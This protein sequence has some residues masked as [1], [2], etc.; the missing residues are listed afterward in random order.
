MAE[1]PDA[2]PEWQEDLAAYV[3]AQGTPE[4]EAALLAHLATCPACRAEADEL[5]AIAAVVLVMDPDRS[6]PAPAGAQPIAPTQD[7]V[8]PPAALG[9]R[10]A[11]RLASERRRNL[12]RRSFVAAIAAA[13]AAVAGVTT[14]H[15]LAD[16]GPGHL[17]GQHFAFA[18]RP[19]GSTVEA[20]VAPYED[21]AS[22]VEIDASGL[23]PDTT[24]ALWLTEPGGTWEDR[25]PA[26]TFRA[27]DDG[28]VDVQLPCA[29]DAD[30][31]ARVWA[32]TPD[33]KVAIDTA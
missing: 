7:D 2:C 28:T 13:A 3:T 21:E 20:V 12:R 14:V 30:K 32:T 33:G 8:H 31:V 29:L 5:L 10:I 18:T 6:A 17:T 15:V 22:V 25:V 16:D 1:R 9:P 26:G 4:R 11:A 23:D 27:D 19:A 24:Y